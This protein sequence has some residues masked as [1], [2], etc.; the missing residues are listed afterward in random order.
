[1]SLLGLDVGTT[2]CKAVVFTVEGKPL[3]SAYEEYDVLR[4]HPGY[5]ELET[6][7]V[8]DQ[9]KTV[10]RRV[11]VNTREDPIQ[12]LTVSSLGEALVP[13]TYDRQ[14]LGNSWLNFDQRGEEYLPAL[15]GLL[16]NEHLYRING[17]TLGNHYSLTKLLWLKAHQP[18][19]YDHTDQF[20]HWS[21]FVSYMLGA[22]PAVDYSLANRT[23]LFD[24]DQ[25]NWSEEL[26]HL[27]GLDLAK[28]PMPVPSGTVIGEVSPH[29]AKQLGLSPSIMIVSGAHDQCAN[30]LGCG[31]IQEGQAMYG[32]GTYICITPVYEQRK[33]PFQMIARGLNTE[34]H[35]VPGLFA[36]FIYN[37][38]GAL[39]KWY[40]D[41]FAAEEKKQARLSRRDI[42]ADLISEIPQLPSEVL[43]LPHF[44]P[45][46]P[47]EFITDSSGVMIGLKLETKR[48][49]ILKG[50]LEGTTYYLKEC[51]DSL[52]AT[53]ISIENFR[54]AGGGSKSNAWIQVC[55]DIMDRPFVRPLIT[56]A[57][58]L[59]A[60][61]LAGLGKGV[62]SCVQTGVEAMVKL[63]RV[64]EPNL[65]HVRKYAQRYEKYRQIWPLLKDLIRQSD[66]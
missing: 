60:A 51:I 63:E 54:A 28:L 7:R 6:V 25:E 26:V 35:A 12:A 58:A 1:V 2:G 66:S 31:V 34:H 24:L 33:D 22:D 57:G 56:E 50:I 55:A 14:V 30:A 18:E 21:G 65:S 47:P 8:W 49:E 15:A 52:P 43:V 42:Y 44:A 38:G 11:A 19:L 59:G 36:S 9:V 23:L 48:G 20:M 45:T 13:V 3:A 27:A 64:F 61:I 32:M 16:G 41:T 10:I 4:T 53:G 46:G 62:F 37:P 39:V 5:A 40:R 17:N 29:V